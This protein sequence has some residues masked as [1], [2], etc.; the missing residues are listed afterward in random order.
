MASDGGVFSF[1]DARFAGSTGASPPF[2]PI[3]G[4]L[5]T[6]DGRGYWLMT[7]AGQIYAFG[8]ATYRGNAP[9]PLAAL[10][11]GIVAT[12]GGYRMV[13]TAGNVFVRTSTASQTRISTPTPL[14]AAG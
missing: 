10:C 9:L 2:F 3:G 5:A 8:D 1:G 7:I 14:V 6:P 4:M 11:M 12:P 13:D